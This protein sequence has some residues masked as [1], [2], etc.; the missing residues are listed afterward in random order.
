MTA[1]TGTTGT[2][3]TAD[4]AGF[5]VVSE[6]DLGVVRT[7]RAQFRPR[8]R[9]VT[10]GLVL[11]LLGVGCWALVMGSFSIP[12]TDVPRIL[13]GDGDH[14]ES[15][16]VNRIRLPRLTLGVLIGVALGIS[17]AVF[18]S[19]VENELASPDIIG[20]TQG[21]SLGAIVCIVVLNSAAPMVST[22]AL[23]GGLATAAV[24]YLLAYK[25]GISG[26]RLILVGIGVGA[27]LGAYTGFLMLRAEED[28]L[29][30]ATLW[31]IGSLN[32]ATWDLA[33][34]LAVALVVFGSMALVL[35]RQ[36]RVLQLG[37]DTSAGIGVRVNASKGAILVAGVGLAAFATAAAGPITFIA[38]V[39]PPATRRMLGNGDPAL[40]LSGLFGAVLLAGADVLGRYGIAG[41]ELP[42]GVV[43]GILGAP[44]LV[45]QLI[46][47][48][49][50]G[51]G[52]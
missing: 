19:L 15:V 20:I 30:R 12:I 1:T 51:T 22:A 50:Q 26:Y 31:L 39:S 48:N 46:R 6:T 17:G 16:V 18:Q 13:L 41:Y 28:E 44:Y 11:A 14:M 45:Y 24:I 7:A 10:I 33:V 37:N 5:G 52:G 34:P 32:G 36:L 2:D 27:C 49:K 38:F 29:A 25:Q 4:P 35:R 40:L 21:S 8:V 42:V 43:T 47:S 3:T 23:G 9:V